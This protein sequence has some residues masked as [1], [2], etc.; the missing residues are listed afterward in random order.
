MRDYRNPLPRKD[1]EWKEKE[2]G[3]T[4]NRLFI[5]SLCLSYRHEKKESRWRPET[6]YRGSALASCA[7]G[8]DARLQ[9]PVIT[10]IELV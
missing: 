10:R 9:R 1:S 3:K 6:G 7:R 5:S 8:S 4:Q 2:E